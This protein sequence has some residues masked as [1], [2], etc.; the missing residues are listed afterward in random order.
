MNTKTTTTED[1]TQEIQDLGYVIH[2]LKN[3]IDNVAGELFALVKVL[4]SSNQK[5]I[6]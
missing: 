6:K 5:L 3:S 1:L 4:E 2:D